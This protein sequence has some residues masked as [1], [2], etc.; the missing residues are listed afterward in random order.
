MG[1]PYMGIPQN[2]CFMMNKTIE[3]DDLAPPIHGNL[4][5]DV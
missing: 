1:V 4:H 2:G 3:I 5:D